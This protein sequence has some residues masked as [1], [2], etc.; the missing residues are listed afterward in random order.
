[1]LA[2]DPMCWQPRRRKRGEHSIASCMSFTNRP[3]QI[4]ILKFHA[5]LCTR[6]TTFSRRCSSAHRL[7]IHRKRERSTCSTSGSP[8]SQPSSS[9][10]AAIRWRRWITM[11]STC[12]TFGRGLTWL[13]T[14]RSFFRRR[15]NARHSINISAATTRNW[16]YSMSNFQRVSLGN[17]RVC[18]ST[19]PI[20]S[21]T[22]PA[23][24]TIAF[25]C[26]PLRHYRFVLL[27]VR[28]PQ[29]PWRTTVFG[30]SSCIAQTPTC[31]I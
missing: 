8:I 7:A 5:W 30:A 26:A 18:G 20:S 6:R 11:W 29:R 28:V 9:S 15:S 4:P 17:R 14:D 25:T 27:S 23:M 13:S 12:W 2:E 21:T 24:A 31:C 16:R 1:M 19:L 3:H 10:E 22:W